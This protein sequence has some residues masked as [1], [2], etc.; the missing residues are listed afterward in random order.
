MNQNREG[1]KEKKKA[2]EKENFQGITIHI[3]RYGR[4]IARYVLWFFFLHTFCLSTSINM[5]F[6]YF[7]AD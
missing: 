7:H 1:E 6:E 3:K 4:F 2:M 5:E